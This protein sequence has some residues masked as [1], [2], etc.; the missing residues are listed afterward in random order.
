M[1]FGEKLKALRKEKGYSQEQLA[2]LLDVSRQAVSKWESDRGL[3]E[4]EKLLQLSGLFGVTLDYLLKEEPLA[5]SPLPVRQPIGLEALD[6]F[7]S[8]Q[9]QGAIRFSAGAGAIVLSDLFHSLFPGRALGSVL[10]W[11]MLAGG[12]CL[13]VWQLLQPKQYQELFTEP[14]LLDEDTRSTFLTEYAR[15][16]RDHIRLVLAGIILLLLGPELAYGARSF[17]PLQICNGLETL[18]N[19]LWVMLFL[20]AGLSMRAETMLA[21]NIGCLA[22][23]R[24]HGVFAWLY[25][26]LPAALLATLVGIVTNAWSQFLPGLLLLCALLVTVCKLLL[27]RRTHK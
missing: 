21:Q 5:V 27:E 22:P 6:G 23:N 1:T 15:R 16:R 9:R 2:A 24:P 7:L 11:S 4:I 18:F 13:I 14:L 26:A 20:F 12:A 19:A 10:C 3:P 25:G 8:Y 17:A